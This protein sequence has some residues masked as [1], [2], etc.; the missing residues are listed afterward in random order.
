MACSPPR[1]RAG[2]RRSPAGLHSRCAGF[3]RAGSFVVATSGYANA[4]LTIVALSLLRL[5]NPSTGTMLQG[6]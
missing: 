1:G 2:L 3:S 5:A 6:L 4:T